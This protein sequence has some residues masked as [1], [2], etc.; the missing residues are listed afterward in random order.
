MGRTL[1]AKQTISYLLLYQ[2]CHPLQEA[3]RLKHRERRIQRRWSHQIFGLIPQLRETDSDRMDKDDRLPLPEWLEGF[4]ENQEEPE[5]I[6]PAHISQGDS[7]SERPTKV[8]E[9]V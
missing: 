4:T 3:V 7:D 6:V 2:V 5:T 8:M 1:F 9:N